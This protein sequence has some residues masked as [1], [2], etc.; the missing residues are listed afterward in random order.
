[1]SNAP[2]K[3]PVA[4]VTDSAAALP[5]RLYVEAGLLVTPMEITLGGK[6]YDDGP[7]GVGDDFYDLLVISSPPRSAKVYIS[8]RTTSLPSP[9]VRANTGVNSKIGVWISLCP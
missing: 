7:E 9:K 1:M 4:V 2:Q 6:T 5:R 8:L 3:L